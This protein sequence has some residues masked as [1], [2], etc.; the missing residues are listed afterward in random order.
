MGEDG[1]WKRYGREKREVEWEEERWHRGGMGEL[2]GGREMAGRREGRWQGG[3][4]GER[5]RQLEESGREVQM[6]R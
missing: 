2:S 3:G 6:V 1:R 5:G 4:M